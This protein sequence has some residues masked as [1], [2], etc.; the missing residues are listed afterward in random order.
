VRNLFTSEAYT[1]TEEA[2]VIVLAFSVRLDKLTRARVGACGFKWDEA[3]KAFVRK[4][5]FDGKNAAEYLRQQ[6]EADL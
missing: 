1:F 4:N 2:G 5:N 3:R 6:L